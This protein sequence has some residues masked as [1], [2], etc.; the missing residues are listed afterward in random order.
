ML[1]TEIIFRLTVYKPKLK[2]LEFKLKTSA[3]YLFKGYFN[4]FDKVSFDRYYYI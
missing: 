1:V 3:F 2:S 4:F